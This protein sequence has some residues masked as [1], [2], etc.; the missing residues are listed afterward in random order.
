MI[1]FL[2][3]PLCFQ[4]WACWTGSPQRRS[5]G[6][7]RRCWRTRTGGRLSCRSWSGPTTG[8]GEWRP[9]LWL[10]TPPPPLQHCG[11]S[12]FSVVIS[13]VWSSADHLSCYPIPRLLSKRNRG[14]RISDPIRSHRGFY[15]GKRRAN[16]SWGE[17]GSLRDNVS[18]RS[19]IRISCQEPWA[20]TD[21][22]Q[23]QLLST[24]DQTSALPVRLL[25]ILVL[26]KSSL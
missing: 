2:P 11:G 16:I 12:G 9:Q 10:M 19:R 8:S 1:W 23:N 7:W 5:G 21:R 15:F 18:V 26:C 25:F 17:D 22:R 4:N 20:L 3:A 6:L 14:N 24:S 13:E